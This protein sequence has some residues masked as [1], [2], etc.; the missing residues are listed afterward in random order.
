MHSNDVGM[1]NDFDRFPIPHKPV[2]SSKESVTESM[3]SISFENSFRLS[4]ETSEQLSPPS[5]F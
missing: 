4:N 1:N 5:G 3:L 2:V